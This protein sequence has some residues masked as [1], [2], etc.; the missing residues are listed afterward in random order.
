[1]VQEPLVRWFVFV[2]IVFVAYVVSTIDSRFRR[3][4]QL[5]LGVCSMIIVV[6]AVIY[7]ITMA[8]GS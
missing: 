2:L 6:E 3:A 5:V 7:L 8:G 4:A 1:V